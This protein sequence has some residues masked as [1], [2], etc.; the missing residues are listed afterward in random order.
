MPLATLY[1]RKNQ[2]MSVYLTSLESSINSAMFTVFSY[3]SPYSESERHFYY[4]PPEANTKYKSFAVRHQQY[5][6]VFY[7]EGSHLS[8]DKN[9][10]TACRSMYEKLNKF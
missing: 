3:P 4:Y 6:A 1:I 10:D 7:T 8:D 2:Q 9:R 5:K